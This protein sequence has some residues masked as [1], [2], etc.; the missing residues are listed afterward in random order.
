MSLGTVR[1]MSELRC[2]SCGVK[3]DVPPG[4][5]IVAEIRA[6]GGKTVGISID[7][8]AAHR[9]ATDARSVAS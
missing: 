6:R 3:V 8:K 5:H 2:P 1:R 9:C 4:H 7:G